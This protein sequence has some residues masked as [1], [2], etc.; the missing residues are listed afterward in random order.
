[1]KIQIVPGSAVHFSHSA[2]SPDASE[3]THWMIVPILDDGEL[4]HQMTGLPDDFVALVQKLTET[5]DFRISEQELLPLYRCREFLSDLENHGSE[6]SVNVLLCGLGRASQ[7]EIGTLRRSLLAAFRR[8]CQQPGQSVTII[9]PALQH[10]SESEIGDGAVEDSGPLMPDASAVLSCCI[11]CAVT[12]PIDVGVYQRERRRFPLASLSVMR[13]PDSLSVSD[14]MIDAGLLWTRGCENSAADGSR[15]NASETLRTDAGRNTDEDPVQ[16]ALPV[17]GRYAISRGVVTGDAVN[18]VRDLVNRCSEDIHPESL[19]ERISELS[20]ASGLTC[21]ILTEADLTRERMGALL[22]VARGSERAPRV[23][24]LRYTGGHAEDPVVALVGKGVTFDSGGYSMKT[25][26]G[27]LTMKSD[28]AGAATVVA[29]TLAAARLRL[30]VNLVACVGLVE[31]LVSGRAFKPGDV[32]T[33]REGTTIEI[34][35][36]DAEGRLV[37]ADLLDFVTDEPLARIIDV[38]TLTGSCVI[39]LGEDVTGLF[40]ND[41]R[42][43]DSVLDA[44]AKAGELMWAM[45]MFRCYDDLLRSDVADVRNIGGRWGG[46]IT[47]AKFLERFVRR[48]PWV[49]LDIAGPSFASSG[50]SFRDS[51]A[52]ACMVRCLLEWLT[53]HDWTQS[54]P[55]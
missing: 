27:M 9:F 7:F 36:T 31:N 26:D 17:T 18:L 25:A 32:L 37:L 44:A 34:Q 53:V 3:S 12:A 47:A 39:A 6:C 43:S 2:A 49:H 33:S 4:S 40:S 19:A 51:G 41:R 5:R 30:P 35:N 11:E 46:S 1:M 42:H 24:R 50:N 15:N 16:R 13:V 23:V 48:V 29:V 10:L 52:T 28:M 14:S 20:I 38:A 54:E 21:E 45:P 55:A 22:A 8:I